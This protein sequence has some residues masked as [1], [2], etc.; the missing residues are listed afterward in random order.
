[1]LPGEDGIWDAIWGIIIIYHLG[2]IPDVEKLPQ[3]E[4]CVNLDDM[5]KV[6]QPGQKKSSELRF[7]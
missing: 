4:R 2:A 1:M 6:R 5:F 7:F 3:L